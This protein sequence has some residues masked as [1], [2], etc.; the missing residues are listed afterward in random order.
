MA[1]YLADLVVLRGRISLY[2][3]GG[4][5]AE[6]ELAAGAVPAGAV[7]LRAD[8]GL[9]IRGTVQPGAAVLRGRVH[10]IV[11]GG[12]GA[13]GTR[14]EGAFRS[15]Q[16]RDP[17]RAIAAA[18]GDTLSSTI[19]STLL[20]RSLAFWTLGAYPAWRALRELANAAGAHWRFLE[21]GTLWLGIETWPAAEL[22][23]T[24]AIIERFPREGRVEIAAATPSLLPGVELVGVGRVAGVDH[25]IEPD[26]VRTWA[27]T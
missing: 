18:T 10:V 17:L 27:W 2:V 13:L 24:D 23:R 4:W 25:W 6:L 20:S 15:A 19:D 26:G 22:P 8:G 3:N 9:S 14:V 16:L 5:T 21:D 1:V 12:A 7:T 11:T